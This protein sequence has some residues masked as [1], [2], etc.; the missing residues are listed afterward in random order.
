[1]GSEGHNRP[2]RLGVRT[3]ACTRSHRFIKPGLSCPHGT[4]TGDSRPRWAVHA[5]PARA[6]SACTR[7]RHLSGS[8]ADGCPLE[9]LHIQLLSHII[10]SRMMWLDK[11]N[12]RMHR[13]ALQ[14]GGAQRWAASGPV[15]VLSATPTCGHDSWCGDVRCLLCCP[16]APGPHMVGGQNCMH[17]TLGMHPSKSCC[18]NGDG[19]LYRTRRS[20]QKRQ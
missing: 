12:G 3:L 2:L 14:S 9:F 7:P 4:R 19:A 13:T 16:P 20:Q 6:V 18:W 5:T 11:A 10:L 15:A 1:M 17:C 8:P